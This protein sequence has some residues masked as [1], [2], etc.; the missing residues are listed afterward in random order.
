MSDQYDIDDHCSFCEG[1]CDFVLRLVKGHDRRFCKDV[2][3][4]CSCKKS[5]GDQN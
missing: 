3:G 2:V 5:S 4:F 1:S